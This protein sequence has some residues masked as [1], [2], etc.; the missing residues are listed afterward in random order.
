MQK[1]NSSGLFHSLFLQQKCNMCTPVIFVIFLKMSNR[2]LSVF[3]SWGK[4]IV[5]LLKIIIIFI[6]MIEIFWA[7]DEI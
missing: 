6:I 1:F 4:M 5:I 7:F 2:L 3:K